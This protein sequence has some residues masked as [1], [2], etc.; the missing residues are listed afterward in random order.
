MRYGEPSVSS[1]FWYVKSEG[2]HYIQRDV[3]EPQVMPGRLIDLLLDMGVCFRVS[4]PLEE[5]KKREDLTVESPV[6]L[7]VNSSYVIVP[8]EIPEAIGLMKLKRVSE[9]KS[10]VWTWCRFDGSQPVVY[11]EAE[12]E[13]LVADSEVFNVKW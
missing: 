3:S 10:Y 1:T 12:M 8:Y 9:D 4:V 6:E 7:E 13:N 2:R 5:F 11:S